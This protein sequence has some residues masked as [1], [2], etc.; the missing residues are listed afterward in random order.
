L[1]YGVKEMSFDTESE[2]FNNRRG[3]W[4]QAGFP[5]K[6][7]H[8]IE[9][10]DME[11][12]SLECEMCESQEIRYVHHMEHPDYDEILKV[13]C[14]C[15]GH[16]E[17]N[18]VSARKRDDFMKSRSSKRERWLQRNWKISSKGN[19]YLR[20]DGYLITIFKKNTEWK[21]VVKN[22]DTDESK[23]S[24]RKYQSSNH[25]KLA[26]FDLITKYLSESQS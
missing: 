13:G 2:H 3:K 5:H 24:K 7:W 25:I 1:K 12:P 26:T 10:E 8:C 14:I 4:S 17:G 16:M 11:E 18:L 15:A 6:G 9:I 19:E 22:L 20:T 23:F 21:A